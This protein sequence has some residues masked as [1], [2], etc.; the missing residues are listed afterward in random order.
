MSPTKD[1][2]YMMLAFVGLALT[3]IGTRGSFFMLPARI[4]LPARVERALHYAPACALTAIVVPGV[5]TRN[6]ALYLDVHNNQMWA[7]LA[8]A[9]VFFKTRNMVVMMAVG[10]TVFTVLRLYA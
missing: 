10:M 6:G 4:N 3:T 2:A 1:W 5:L 9:A 7:V 8:A